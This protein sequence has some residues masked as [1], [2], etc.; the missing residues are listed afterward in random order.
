LNSLK[1]FDNHPDNR[2]N[3]D[4]Y[5]YAEESVFKPCNIKRWQVEINPKKK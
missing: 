4:D 2:E 5:K 3:I 1:E